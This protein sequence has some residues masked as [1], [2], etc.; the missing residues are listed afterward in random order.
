MNQSD[1][2]TIHTLWEDI[3]TVL[4]RRQRLV[5]ITALATAVT[6]YVGLLFVSDQYDAESSLLVTIGRENSEVPLTVERGTVFS[7]GVK[8]EEV[9]SYISM[10]TSPPVVSAAIDEVGLDRFKRH[11]D[12]PK[13]LIGKIKSA[14]KSL[15]RSAKEGM[16]EALIRIALRPRLSEREQVRLLIDKNLKA[17]REKDSSVI[18]LSLRLSDPNLAKDVLT[19][20]EKQFLAKH[21]EMV[22]H[23]GPLV[24][25][26]EEQAQAYGKRLSNLRESSATLKRDLGVSSVTEQKTHLL[27]MLKSAKLGE[28]ENERELARLNAEQ[29]ALAKRRPQIEEQLVGTMVVSPSVSQTRARDLLAE[30]SLKQAQAIA[31]YNSNA[32]PLLKIQ[33]E[34]A[35][36]QAL[37]NTSA[38]EDN[39]P[40]TLMRNPVAAQMD[41]QQEENQIKIA[42]LKASVAETEKQVAQI[43]TE[44]QRMDQAETELQKLQLE[45]SVAEAR[46]VANASKREE[47]RTQE[48]MDQQKMANVSILSAPNFSEKPAAPKRLLIMGL[49]L[50]AGIMSGIGL[51]LFLEWQSD[52]IH[53]E[54]DLE[55]IAG[56]TFL[57][58]FDMGNSR[59]KNGNGAREPLTPLV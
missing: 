5:W 30:L 12:N 16:N 57:G 43:T 21:A 23:S 44:L 11:P 37:A 27:E 56:G 4:R 41:I 58:T 31:K 17:Y 46:F 19:A 55:R 28:Q 42:A 14:A 15:V 52:L 26:F 36:V 20:V 54:R 13:T 39:G 35:E 2:L 10:L 45:I 6:V 25:M 51:G 34:I 48:I 33:Q 50:V 24:Q 9:I 7:D 32:E 59:I 22:R 18:T 3:L 8:K 1:T 40:K 53:S 49:G 47:A 29:E 38:R